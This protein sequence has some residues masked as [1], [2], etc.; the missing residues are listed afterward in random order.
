MSD[1]PN[2]KKRAG[3]RDD[4]REIIFGVETP[5]GKAFDVAL[6]WCIVLSVVAVMLES[7]PEVRDRP[8]WGLGLDMA[9]WFFTIVFT[10]E[11]AARLACA[12]RPMRY[13]T[14]FYGAVDLVSILPTYLEL[15]VPG[16]QSL[17]VIRALRLLRVFR[18]LKLI[19]FMKD[20]DLL[21]VALLNSRRKIFT[22]LG[23]VLVIVM[24]VGTLMYLIE[25]TIEDSGFNS[26]PQSMYW[27]IVTIT[28]VG[29]GD[30]TPKTP[31]GQFLASVLMLIGY[32]I[33]AVPTGIVSVE[34]AQAAEDQRPTVACERCGEGGLRESARYCDRCGQRLMASRD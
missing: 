32:S 21:M 19:A 7:V 22:F 12:K 10:I 14:S 9:E 31:M 6:L 13:A 27:A 20:A 15:L 1:Q 30:I 25:S 8:G 5:A 4:L 16:A 2:P 11:Y 28:T 33:I 18:V 17:I 23:T 3:W 26:I 29:F 34:L 24:I